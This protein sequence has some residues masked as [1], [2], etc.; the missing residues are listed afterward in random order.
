MIITIDAD[1]QLD[2]ECLTEELEELEKFYYIPDLSDPTS[3][4]YYIR[5]DAFS[6]RGFLPTG[7]SFL[8]RQESATT[9]IGV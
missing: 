7:I 3:I 6:D 5:E 1:L 2:T 9:I 8:D 4:A